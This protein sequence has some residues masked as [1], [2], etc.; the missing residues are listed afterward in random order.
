[1]YA[2][3]S[4]YVLIYGIPAFR[5]PKNVVATEIN[6]L[7]Q[8]GVDFHLNSVGGRASGGGSPRVVANS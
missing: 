6:G 7:R 5:L 3:R 4:Y 1:M 2:I 8:A